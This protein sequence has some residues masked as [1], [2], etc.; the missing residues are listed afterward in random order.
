MNTPG[1]QA[2]ATMWWNVQSR[3]CS[4]SPSGAIGRETP[5]PV[6]DRTTH[7][8]SAAERPSIWPRVNSARLEAELRR[9]CGTACSAQPQTDRHTTIRL[10]AYDTGTKA[11]RLPRLSRP[12]GFRCARLVCVTL[13]PLATPVLATVDSIVLATRT[14]VGRQPG[15]HVS[16]AV[17]VA[18]GI[19]EVRDTRRSQRQGAYGWPFRGA[20]IQSLAGHNQTTQEG[21]PR[22]TSGTTRRRTNTDRTSRRGPAVALCTA[23]GRARRA[24]CRAVEHLRPA[25]EM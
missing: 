8:I 1:D 16:T 20:G 3:T 21:E 5:V 12:L 18:G 25:T 9:A 22:P 4:S 11:G 23:C 2:S 7:T 17:A 24:C 10:C 19:Q 6:R 14:V 13:I 15:G